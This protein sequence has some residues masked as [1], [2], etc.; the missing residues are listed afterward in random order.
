[1]TRHIPAALY[2]LSCVGAIVV[3]VLRGGRWRP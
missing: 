3:N 2:A 1:M